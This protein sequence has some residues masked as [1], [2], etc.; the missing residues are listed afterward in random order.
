[1][2][3]V[4]RRRRRSAVSLRGAAER[5]KHY[6]TV[7]AGSL[8]L[9]GGKAL[10]GPLHAQI[11]ISDPCN[12]RCVMCWDHA[13]A[14]RQSDAT[15]NRFGFLREGIMTFET[16]KGI[17]DDL[18]T[19]GTRRIDIV[20]RGEPTLNARVVEMVRYAKGRGM[21]LTMTTNGSRLW[22]DRADAFVAA[23]LDRLKI[24][25]NAGT[26]EN[27]PN[28]HVSETPDNYLKVKANL[29][30]L[31]DRK[32]ATGRRAPHVT[33]SFVVSAKNYFE[34]EQMVRVVAEVGADEGSFVHTVIHDGTPDLALTRDQYAEL[35]RTVPRARAVADELGVVTNLATLHATVPTYLNDAITGPPVV[36][37]YV[38][39]YFTVVLGNGSVMPCCQCNKPLDQVTE[40]RG[41]ADIW[42]S[43]TYARFRTAAKNL[44]NPSNILASCEC[45]RCM[46]RPRNI[47]IHNM[48]HPWNRI[49][50]GDDEQLFTIA[51]LM[52]MKKVDRA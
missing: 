35:Q 11:G 39:W 43:D 1:M 5:L 47:S 34:I 24:S 21:L 33:L 18:H 2:A 42:G 50:G 29:R 13:P 27:Y 48:L 31:A 19:L 49:E 41:F 36:P 7:A 8:G 44:P 14:D 22:Q 15:Q 20:G 4:P 46:L 37:C 17:V 28:I 45:D 10:S 6:S 23:G 51:D 30:Y 3:V 9:V 32:L 40:E 52:R 25:M 16:F 38:G 26:P 12:H